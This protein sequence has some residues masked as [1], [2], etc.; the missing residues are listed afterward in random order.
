MKRMIFGAVSVAAIAVGIIL[1][2]STLTGAR[3]SGDAA[4]LAVGT[5]KQLWQQQVGYITTVAE[6][7]SEADYAYK[8]TK[9]VRSVGQLIAHVAGAQ[10]LMCAAALGDPPRDETEIEKS[11]KTKAEI[12]AA[13]K[14]STQYC[15]R[16]YAQTDEA[17]AAPAKLFGR[18]FTRLFALGLNAV[19]DGEHYG[20]LVTYMRMKGMV[21]PS[22]R[23]GP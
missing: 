10:N 21:P 20:N 5:H 18:D 11:A 9:D 17:A 12:V 7:L 19:H 8:P 4:T 1:S 16:A 13:L 15:M 3:A 2:S 23:S 6:E 22:S 14:A